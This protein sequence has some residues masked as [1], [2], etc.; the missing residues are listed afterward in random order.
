[1]HGLDDL[2]HGRAPGYRDPASRA[3]SLAVDVGMGVEESGQHGT[4]G[5]IDA[6]GLGSGIREER[7]RGPDADDAVAAHRHRLGHA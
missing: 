1:M 3:Q 5:E 6:S 7:R 4:P 2:H